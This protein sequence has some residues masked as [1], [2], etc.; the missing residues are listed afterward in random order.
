MH[1]SI[2]ELVGALQHS[3][4]TVEQRVTERTEELKHAMQHAEE[5]NRAKSAFLANMSHELRTT[6]NV[7]LGFAQLMQRDDSIGASQREN[8]GVI[9]KSGEHLLNLIADVLE[10]SKIEAGQSVLTESVFNLHRLLAGIEDIFRL[11][12]KEKGLDLVLDL[13]EGPQY[14]TGDEEKLRQVLMNLLSNAV[15]F[16]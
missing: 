2:K 10:M 15:K 3:N 12:A 8:L 13:G 9:G 16:T 5:A 6:L 4:Q 14:V 11:L 1:D 7:I